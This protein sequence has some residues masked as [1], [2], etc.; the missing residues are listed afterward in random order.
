MVWCCLA[1]SKLI[2][3]GFSVGLPRHRRR[4]ASHRVGSKKTTPGGSVRYRKP[5]DYPPS[6]H[7]R[8]FVVFT[9]FIAGNEGACAISFEPLSPSIPTD[10]TVKTSSLI[11]PS[12]LFHYSAGTCNYIFK[13]SETSLRFIIAARDC[14]PAG[15]ARPALGHALSAG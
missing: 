4:K 9:W 15:T 1:A 8:E 6:Q 10:Q 2:S 5:A 3:S 14:E 7:G 13:I 12:M 11:T